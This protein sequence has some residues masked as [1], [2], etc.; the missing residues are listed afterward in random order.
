VLKGILETVKI[1]VIRSKK[2]NEYANTE[3]RYNLVID[4]ALALIFQRLHP[5]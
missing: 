3:F 4:I 5:A 1:I 2:N